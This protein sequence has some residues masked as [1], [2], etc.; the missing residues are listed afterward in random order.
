MIPI[1]LGEGIPLIPPGRRLAL[2][3]TGQRTYEGSG[4]VM[5]EYVVKR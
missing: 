5:L 4:T 1:L 3:L 2:S